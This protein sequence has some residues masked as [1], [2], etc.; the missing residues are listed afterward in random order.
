VTNEFIIQ[1]ITHITLD[2]YVH[3]CLNFI[4]YLTVFRYIERD[5]SIDYGQIYA[6]NL[7]SLS[8]VTSVYAYDGSGN[9]EPVRG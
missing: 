3:K 5:E 1:P 2:V 7:F 9:R 8:Y 6:L 4:T